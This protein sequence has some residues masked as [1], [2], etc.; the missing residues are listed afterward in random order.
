[1]GLQHGETRAASAPAAGDT[2]TSTRRRGVR[3]PHGLRIALGIFQWVVMMTIK[4]NDNNAYVEQ[5][6]NDI[7]AHKRILVVASGKKYIMPGFAL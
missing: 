4:N 1:M 7:I 2:V 3:K 6:K 5:V